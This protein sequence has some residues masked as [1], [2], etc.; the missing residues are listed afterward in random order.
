MTSNRDPGIRNASREPD[1]GKPDPAENRADLT[2]RREFLT[3]AAYGAVALSAAG[4]V[5]VA[6]VAASHGPPSGPLGVFSKNQAATYAAWCDV[7]VIGAA[8][9]GVARFVDKYLARPYPVSLLMLRYLQN[10]PFVDFY[11][12]GVAGV[13]EESQVRFSKP[14]LELSV[15]ERRSVVDAAATSSTMA[16]TDPAPF[17]FYFISRADAVDVVYGTV[18]GFRDLGV[19]YVPHIRPRRP[20]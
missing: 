10:P 19:P 1:S 16:W 20:W 17:F 2:S 8:R 7:L 5:S 14:F 15:K 13:D 18:R 12:N 3:R 11:L 6:G 9:A 4:C